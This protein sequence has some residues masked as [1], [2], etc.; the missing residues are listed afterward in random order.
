MTLLTEG[1]P[2]KKLISFAIPIALGRLL[3]VLYTMTDTKIIG[4]LL[5]VSALASVSSVTPLCHLLYVFIDGAALGFGI[6]MAGANGR[7]DK[8]KVKAAFAVSLCLITAITLFLALFMLIFM[9]S[10]LFVLRVPENEVYLAKEYLRIICLG[11]VI[12]ALNNLLTNTLRSVGI[13]FVPLVILGIS[14]LSNII[15]DFI[16]IGL[17]QWGTGGAAL[18]TVLSQAIST[19]SCIFY[20]HHK[21]DVL[22]LNKGK[23]TIGME[24]LPALIRSGASM[25]LQ[26]CIVNI[27]T[28][29]LQM[30]INALDIAVIVAHS[31]A[32]KIFELGYIPY[33]S[34][35][36]A[37]VT[38]TASNY[39]A[40]QIKRVK[41][42]YL[43]A[44][45]TLFVWSGILTLISNCLSEQFIRFFAS[46]DR[47]EILLWGTR[48]LKVEMPSMAICGIVI[49]SRNLLQGMDDR[50]VPVLSSVM[51]LFVKGLCAFVS[52][53]FIGYWGVI[54]AEPLSWLC[55]S[56]LL[57]YE[58][59]RISKKIK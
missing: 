2:G 21:V 35:G 28:V 44:L 10:L 43:T 4:L 27:G 13:S 47:P 34:L 19:I 7:K 9:D 31:S 18:A 25:G 57:L 8:E 50:G 45:K 56:V 22:K 26:S 36:F 59:H 55:M 40:G 11:L 58:V 3:Q 32:R 6:T 5:G 53:R 39:G 48:Y 41:Q 12:T 16:F 54:I 52:L 37:L 29:I 42:G 15:L 38:Y 51:E 17:V 20:I 23:M 1:N 24:L 14:S 30:S 33:A 46:S 49:L